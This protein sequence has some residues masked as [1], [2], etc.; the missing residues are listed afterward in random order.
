MASPE[1]MEQDRIY[2][3]L[4]NDRIEWMY[5][6]PDS[7]SEGQF[8]TNVFDRDLL[9]EAASGK[10][11][12]GEIFDY[13]GSQCR[14]YLSDRGTDFFGESWKRME[15]EHPFAIGCSLTTIENLRLA[16]LAKDHINEYC[17]REFGSHAD[18]TDL[19]KIGIGYTT[20]TDAE[21]EVQVY[22]NLLDHRIEVY[23]NGSLAQYA[24]YSSLL[25]MVHSGLP[26][27]EFDDL[28]Y[29]PDWVIAN[30]E[31]TALVEDLAVRLT[32]FMKD[33][34]YYGYADIME[35]GETDADMVD[36]MKGD[37]SDPDLIRNIMEELE[38]IIQ[39][40]N[41]SGADK[42]KC[43]DMMTDLYHLL[44]EEMFVPVYDRETDILYT[45]FDVLG[46]EGYEL[47]FDN[48]GICMKK[49]DAEWH[50]AD[51]YRHLAQSISVEACREFRDKSFMN[52][53]DFKDLAAHYGVRIG[54]QFRQPPVARLDFL[55][56][57]GAVG[58]SVEYH[59]EAA[60]LKA[61]KEELQYGVPLTVVLYRDDTG[62]TL[63][64]NFLE[65]LDT[66]PKGLT[67]ENAPQSGKKPTERSDAR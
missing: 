31:R 5:Y 19:R 12:A 57:N 23:L 26:H 65:D 32:F 63:S 54:T 16:Y 1:F 17:Q 22:A 55:G 27:L 51:I 62:K 25:D 33:Y 67:V 36:R 3:D 53:T 50:D 6:N 4:E 11:E 10:M 20:I 15:T 8:V 41:L 40:G 14:Q 7:V 2:L 9:E 18:F 44:A 66:M 64:R 56:S 43:Y 34:D 61:L 37:L 35:V 48:D 49:G 30:H 21:H 45:A 47:S 58:D 52:Y 42:A 38:K 39:E 46:L 60:F 24:Q 59:T 29:I 28:I 13:I